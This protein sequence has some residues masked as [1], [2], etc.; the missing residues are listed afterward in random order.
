LTRPFDKHLDNDELDGFV[1]SR[2]AGVTDS[3]RLSD[4]ALGEAQRHL[5]SCQDCSRKVQLHKSVQSEI[6]R[7]GLHSN[8]PPGP[9]C[10][11]DTEWLNVAAGLLPEAKAR[12]LV[13]HA[14]QCG[15]CG[16]LL[17]NAAETLSDEV[18]PREE[19]L[20]ASLSSAH[21]DWQRNMASTLRDGVRERQQNPS[22]WRA[23]VAW[24]TPAYAFAAVA[25]VA[26]VAWIGVRTLRPPSAEQ[27]LAQAY[28]ERRT[29]E[30]RIPGAKYAP[31]R[32]ERSD[33]GSNFDKPESLLKAE[34]L[35]GDN[36][37]QSPNDPIWLQAKARAELLD[38]NNDEAIKALQRA[39]ES[40][41]DSPQ[42][43]TDLGS[44]YFLRAKSADRAIDYGNAIESLG[45]A[46]A[47][48]P[49]DPIALFNRA[50]A[51]EQIFLYT[52]AIDDWE[53]YLQV[54]PQSEW[55]D[56]A[57]KRLSAVK[58]KI[59]QHSQ[60]QAEPLLSPSEFVQLAGRD[61]KSVLDSRAEDYL[62]RSIEQWLPAAFSSPGTGDSTNLQAV[63]FLANILV[64]RH[65]DY[66]LS[67][68]LAKSA[69]ARFVE[70]IHSLSDALSANA[71][72]DPDSA[73]TKAQRA[74]QNFEKADNTAGKLRAEA[75]IA[76]ALHRKYRLQ[77]CQWQIARVQRANTTDR[78]PWIA[79]QF[80]LEQYACGAVS[81]ASAERLLSSARKR[82]RSANYSTLYLRALGFSAST[83]TDSGA[84]EKGWLWDCEGLAYYWA[85]NYRP[86]RA[87]HFYDDMSIAAQ[88]SAEWWLAVA[89][90]QEA[91]SAIAASPNRSGEGIERLKLARS[92]SMARLWTGAASQYQ[93]ALSAFSALP[94]DKSNRAFRATAEIGLADVAIS[95]HRS[96]DAEQ[97]LRYAQDNIPP[98]FEDGDTWLSL[99]RT[100]AKF[101][102]GVGDQ[103]GAQKYC[104]AAVLVAEI[105]LH[106]VS[107]ETDRLRWNQA[108]SDCYRALVQLKL[109][110]H[111]ETSALELW[112]WYR[113][114]GTRAKQTSSHQNNFANLDQSPLL[115][116][117][118]E[119]VEDLP[120][121]EH[122][123]VVAYAQ[124]DEQVG[125][126]V[127]D[128]RGIYWMRLAK[129]AA[130][131]KDAAQFATQCGDPQSDPGVL[132]GELYRVLF[133]P[134]L[135]YLDP[136]RT[137]VIEADDQLSVIPFAA[138]HEPDGE[139][140]IDRFKIVYLPAIGFRH[141][142]REPVP[143]SPQ[144][145]AVVVDS[146]LLSDR[147]QRSYAQLPDADAEARYI[148]AQFS[149]SVR[150]SGKEA[151]L[152][153]L[154]RTL[155]NA[156]IFHFAGHTRLQPGH[157]GLLLAPE[158]D[159]ADSAVL[160][161]DEVESHLLVNL[162]LAVLSAC[163]TESM[164][165]DVNAADSLAHAFLR[166]GVPSV[167]ATKWTVDSAATGSLM[168]G[169]YRHLI[170]GEDVPTALQASMKQVRA[171]AG[172]AHPYYWAGVEVFGRIT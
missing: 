8:K 172:Y 113:G 52:Q 110:Q 124:L 43:L 70:A 106:D 28:T 78:Y 15:H 97:H 11:A 102:S 59:K 164:G 141:V 38:G 160:S 36:L 18:T 56:E 161:A 32:V 153:A 100:L 165:S 119:V 39:L 3:M 156:A 20:L 116:P 7:M 117:M 89:L 83:E 82:A 132:G 10:V 91:V 154:W 166:S 93:S 109:A 95:Q 81:I 23:I 27:L 149:H 57:R 127:Y 62:D 135:P 19:T 152:S 31:L 48:N 75:E 144:D 2:A 1:S 108:G 125:A 122:E 73:L 30:V 26:V 115:P 167:V 146:P 14:A 22:W 29:L 41:P 139:Y 103:E 9:D 84:V 128:N 162:R 55:S 60:N 88:N 5:D 155:P 61:D 69:S 121:L 134:L 40:K 150:I 96:S 136:K 159:S 46:L 120:S 158:S 118:H 13:K 126:W 63:Q 147:D 42:L 131:L 86:L 94:Q 44:A 170:E 72:G 47:E 79:V 133:Q 169:L 129:G 4:E 12:E 77:A 45:K 67:D 37:R 87:Q 107:S 33:K 148:A 99:Y 114:A 49:N 112:E 140:L 76:Y 101:K 21:L 35:I 66:W 111:N 53:H 58:E 142:L 130:V 90:E 34:V 24:P 123:T 171:Q 138:L 98:D 25:A 105:D 50:L 80:E 16:P 151:T 71:A 68:L 104:E 85:G 74:L 54:D 92:A 17:K 64:S 65:H 145:F 157:T 6:Q 51:C 143:I 168:Q 137:L 163:A